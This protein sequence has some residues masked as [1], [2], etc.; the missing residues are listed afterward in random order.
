MPT[1]Y[2]IPNCDSVKKAKAWFAQQ[3][4]A[5]TFVDFKKTPPTKP[6]V[7]EWLAA[8]GRDVLL[9]RR[10]LAWRGVDEVTR[11]QVL[12][13]DTALVAL[14]VENPLLIK[15]PVVAFEGGLLTVGVNEALW[16]EALG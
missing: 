7:D 9:N 16:R 13:D 2:G 6:M 1:L 15:R 10:G 4:V 14:L 12:D 5:I 3:D 11:A 8:V